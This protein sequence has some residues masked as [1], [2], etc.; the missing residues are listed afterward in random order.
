MEKNII[1]AGV[2]GQ[3]ILTIAYVLDNVAMSSGW[4]VKQS[5][6][7]GMSQRGGAVYT[8]IRI[9]QETIHSDLVP[10]GG[11]DVIVGIEPMEALR[12]LDQLKPDGIVVTNTVPEI[13]IPDYPDPEEVLTRLRSN[14]ANVLLDART[15]AQKAGNARSQNIVLVGALS[16]YL[17]FPEELYKKH[18]AELFARKGENIVRINHKAFD[19]GREAVGGAA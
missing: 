1:L 4:N 5:E 10:L 6:V 15:L 17:N 14:P 18:I 12:Y 3:G 8:H 11:A 7:H 19:L 9:S 2:G 13:N 16:R